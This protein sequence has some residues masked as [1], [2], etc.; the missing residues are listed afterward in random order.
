MQYR[1]NLTQAKIAQIVQPMLLAYRHRSHR[2]VAQFDFD[3]PQ[4][5]SG[6]RMYARTF[7][8]PVGDAPEIHARLGSF[9]QAQ[10]DHLCDARRL[11]PRC[12]AIEAVTLIAVIAAER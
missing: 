3:L 11:D 1:A 9:L 2:K 5:G 10:Q 8:A 4:C 7:G 12:V 6:V